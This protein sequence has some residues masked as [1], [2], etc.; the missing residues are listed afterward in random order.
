MAIRNSG[1]VRI[2][3]EGWVVILGYRGHY[4]LFHFR[5]F[6]NCRVS[7]SVNKNISSLPVFV[8]M[9]VNNDDVDKMGL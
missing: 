9:T 7:F 2:P 6:G 3:S 1:W 8:S 4:T 5:S